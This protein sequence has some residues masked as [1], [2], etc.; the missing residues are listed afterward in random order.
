MV[1]WLVSLKLSNEIAKFKDL[2][3]K[4]VE[5][6]KILTYSLLGQGYDM[7][8]KNKQGL[9]MGVNRFTAETLKGFS[10]STVIGKSDGDIY[11]ASIASQYKENDLLVMTSRQLILLEETYVSSRD[12]STNTQ[13]LSIKIPVYDENNK[14]IGVIGQ[15]KPINKLLALQNIQKFFSFPDTEA[16]IQRV[17]FLAIF[18]LLSGGSMQAVRT[19]P[20]L[21]RREKEIAYYLLRS[22]SATEIAKSLAISIRTVETHLNHM[23]SK[24]R[25]S[26]KLQLVNKLFELCANIFNV[27]ELL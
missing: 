1:R 20:T 19:C 26:N 18:A 9:Y 22:Y 23:K 16:F 4:Q 7:Y 21:S 14:V 3:G 27:K 24:L 13:G 2:V 11:E 15:S 8:W 5:G 25:C 17:R 6:I 10:N 12:V